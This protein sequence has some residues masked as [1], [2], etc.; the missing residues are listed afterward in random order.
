MSDFLKNIQKGSESPDVHNPLK[1]AQTAMQPEL[2]K[3]FYKKAWVEAK[4]GA[5]LVLLDG[6][7][8]RTPGKNQVCLPTQASAQVVCEEWQAQETVIDPKRMHATRIVNTAIDGIAR[9]LE[10]VRGDIVNYAGTDLLCY[11]ADNPE[12]LVENQSRHWDPL[13]DWVNEE[14]GAD[15]VRAEGIVHVSQPADTLTAFAKAVAQFDQPIALACLHTFTTL[16]GSA[17]IALA[18]AR[19]RLT[20]DAA[21]K[22]AHVDEHW[23]ESLW[24]EDF[25]AMAA[26]ARKFEELEAGHT[27]MR[28]LD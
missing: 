12:G 4:D 19:K 1:A 28:A 16:S 24:G 20:P 7:P 6:K 13:L 9:D 10:T 8:I 2:P 17:I 11:R 18:L 5:Y 14:I 21:W 26:R 27:L 25:D 3:R 15:F 23:N 22:A